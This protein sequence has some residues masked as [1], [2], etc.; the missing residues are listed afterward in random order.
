MFVT[1]VKPSSIK[2]PALFSEL[3]NLLNAVANQTFGNIAKDFTSVHPAINIL[4]N[5]QTYCI[6][7]AAPGLAKED[8]QI[9][10]D[11]NILK[12]EVKK[13]SVK[14]DNELPKVWR[15]EF[16]YFNFEKTF[17]LP[18]SVD[19]ENIRANYEAGILS[20]NINKKAEAT[21]KQITLG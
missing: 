6:E 11:K 18:N 2:S 15:K 7:L 16:S 3:D 19:I 8:F 10:V 21:P 17:N 20:I 4:E 1:T 9:S 13:E 5:A 12:I 14:E